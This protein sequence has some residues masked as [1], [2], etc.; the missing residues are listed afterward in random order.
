MHL[1]GDFDGH[2]RRRRF[3][4]RWPMLV[5]C[6]ICLRWW[7]GDG[8][9]FCLNS[10][11]IP[12]VF[13]HMLMVSKQ[14]LVCLGP[15]FFVG[16]HPILLATPPIHLKSYLLGL[17]CLAHSLEVFLAIIHPSQGPYP[18]SRPISLFLLVFLLIVSLIWLVTF[19][20]LINSW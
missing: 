6:W 8:T 12:F 11:L 17:Q 10:N 9:R 13:Y 5:L 2:R 3:L 4:T 14:A 20:C 16:H 15:G 18:L 7:N 19:F 1:F